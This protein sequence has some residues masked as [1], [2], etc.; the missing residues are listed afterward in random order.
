MVPFYWLRDISSSVAIRNKKSSGYATEAF[1]FVI[2]KIPW[3][4]EGECPI[5]S[6]LMPKV[7][8]EHRPGYIYWGFP[9]NSLKNAF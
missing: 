1:S 9:L 8:P 6:L 3:A 2:A 5:V 4:L 7:T